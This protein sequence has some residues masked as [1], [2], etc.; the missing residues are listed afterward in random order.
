MAAEARRL[1]PDLSWAAVAGRYVDARALVAAGGR[2]V[3]AC[4]MLAPLM[5]ARR[6]PMLPAWR[7][8]L[9]MSDGDRDLRAR[10]LR[11]S[12][13]RTRLLHR[14]RGAAADRDRSRAGTRSR[15]QS[16]SPGCAFR[17]LVD[18]QGVTGRIRNRRDADGRWHGRRSVEDCWGRSVWAFG[19]AARLAPDRV[20]ARAAPCRT[21][22]TP[23]GSARRIVGRWPSPRSAQPNCSPSSRATRGRCELLARRRRHDRPGRRR[24]WRGPG[25]NLACRTPTR[26]SPRR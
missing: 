19:S 14:R 20:D 10:R 5:P 13:A 16:S 21:S 12:A 6:A 1:A 3:P 8:V 18:A 15:T 25:P 22:V 2:P 7:H 9:T 23:S 11:R 26:R 4:D 17:F 24:R